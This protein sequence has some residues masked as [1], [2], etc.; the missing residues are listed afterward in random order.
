MSEK[1]KKDICLIKGYCK[2][3]GVVHRYETEK[4][5]EYTHPTLIKVLKK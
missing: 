3:H 4:E 2:K 1:D 5:A